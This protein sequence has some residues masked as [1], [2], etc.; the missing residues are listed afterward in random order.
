MKLVR[1]VRE[2]CL[3]CK[4]QS[5]KAV[6][7][8]INSTCVFH[9]Y[10][11]HDVCEGEPERK[12][13]IVHYVASPVSEEKQEPIHKEIKPIGNLAT[14]IA[15]LL[16]GHCCNYSTGGQCGIKGVCKQSGCEEIVCVWFKEAVLPLNRALELEINGLNI[17]LEES[18]EQTSRIKQKQCDIC[19]KTFTSIARTTTQCPKC[20][21]MNLQ[22]EETEAH[23]KAYTRKA[24]SICG[25]YFVPKSN[26]SKYCKKCSQKVH[27]KQ[28]ANSV[29]KNRAKKRD[30]SKTLGQF[31]NV[32]R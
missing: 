18:Q 15:N 26:R 30:H 29:R 7:D 8:C 17:S 10:R 20:T 32:I 23:E 25:N 19:G 13:R 22:K 24:C 14:K 5:H 3:K 12:Q 2:H 1:K 21:S 9:A 16:K 27:N 11:L 6:E 28:T 4:R 31:P